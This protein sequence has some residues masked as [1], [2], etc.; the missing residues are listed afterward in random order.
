MPIT[1]MTQK[2]SHTQADK[3]TTSKATSK[4]Y[5][6]QGFYHW[7]E[8]PLVLFL[9]RQNMSFVT[10]KVCLSWQIFAATKVL[11][12]AYLC[13]DK[14]VFVATKHIFCHDKSFEATKDTFCRDK[15]VFVA[16]KMILVAAPINDRFSLFGSRDRSSSSTEGPNS[17]GNHSI[18]R[19]I[20]TT[21]QKS[22]VLR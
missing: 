17:S 18:C 21:W 7:R 11:S 19:L 22:K 8:L 5:K 2:R 3:A 15:H 16:T 13:R 14:Q 9:S 6:L 1:P 20:Y 12:Q 4:T 10:T